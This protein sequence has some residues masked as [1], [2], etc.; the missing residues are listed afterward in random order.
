MKPQ[1]RCYEESFRLTDKLARASLHIANGNTSL[2]NEE[3]YDILIPN[4]RATRDF[5]Q[6]QNLIKYYGE[7]Y[8]ILP[9]VRNAAVQ[10]GINGMPILR[11]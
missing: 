4:Y 5:I 3:K 11:L 6:T 7:E 10:S 2:T 9:Y 1:L 8:E